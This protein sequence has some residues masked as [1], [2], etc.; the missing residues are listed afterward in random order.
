MEI[1]KLNGYLDGGTI[2]IT[3]NEDIYS[4]DSRIRTKT[5]GYIYLG[6][7]NKDDSNILLNQE[8]IKIKLLEAIENYD[9]S[10][11]AFKF[12]PSIIRLLKN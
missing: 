9:E 12:K 6:Y 2:M 10:D 3:T 8:E 11:I 4:I 1:L 5:K 7:P